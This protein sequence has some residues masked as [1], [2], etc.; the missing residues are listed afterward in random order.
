VGVEEEV[1]LLDPVSFDLTPRA[2]ELVGRLPDDGRFKLELPAAQLEIVTSPCDGPVAALDELARG[3][4]ELAAAAEGLARPAVAGV[5]PFAA[6]RG[7][8]NS[9]ER[10]A[11]IHAEFASVGERQLVA[12]LQVHVAVGGAERTLAVLNAL[13][14]LLPELTALAANAP[15]HE[16]R[17]TGLASVR[18]LIAGQ[19]PR[20]GVPPR[21][22]S[23]EH[24][25]SE[26]AW[27]AAAGLRPERSFWWWEL[28]PHLLHGT[29]E[30]RVPDAQ[31][32]LDDAA[33]VIAFVHALV[34]W[35][36]ER[37][38]AGEPLPDAPWWRIHENRWAALRYGLG[39]Q[40]ADLET[41]R[42]QPTRERL[43]ALVEEVRP[44]ALRRGGG[45]LLERTR[46]LVEGGG[47]AGRQRDF[48]QQ[49]GGDVRGLAGWLAGRFTAG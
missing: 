31:T 47:G 22:E 12:G 48:L 42:P 14:C 24:V 26:L 33:G 13:R 35:L 16:G 19:L 43:L 3:R 1:M 9:S 8:L 39:G 28:R 30:I 7:T 15:V 20:Q 37:W 2:V 6:A 17:D 44:V 40:L 23:W 45:A 10:Y 5:H 36:A 46:A 25:A 21:F 38:E 27:G 49:S 11:Q 34:G 41:G 4:A 18:P 32:G 29:L